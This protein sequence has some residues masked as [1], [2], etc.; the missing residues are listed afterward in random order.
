MAPL[1][2]RQAVSSDV[3]PIAELL[4]AVGLCK[5][6]GLRVKI[7]QSIERSPETCLVILDGS[8]LIGAALSFFNGF[9]VFL[10]HIAVVAERQRTGAGRILHGELVDRGRKLGAAGIITDSWL[11]STGFYYRLGYRVPGAVF[12]ISSLK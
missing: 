6:E 8:D 10:S 3:E 5:P 7:R 4:V 11:T 1:R 12:L 2:V 9:H